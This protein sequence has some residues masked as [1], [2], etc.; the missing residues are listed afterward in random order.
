MEPSFKARLKKA[1]TKSD[2]ERHEKQIKDRMK[3][4][5]NK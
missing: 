5:T 1:V 3:M 4:Q 2:S